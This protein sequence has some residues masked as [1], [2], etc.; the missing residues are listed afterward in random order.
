M[1]GRR[2]QMDNGRLATAYDQKSVAIVSHRQVIHDREWCQNG[3]RRVKDILDATGQVLVQQL[4]EKVPQ[5]ADFYLKVNKVVNAIPNEWRRLIRRNNAQETEN[6]DYSELTVVVI[7]AIKVDLTVS[8]RKDLYAILIPK[9]ES[10]RVERYWCEKFNLDMSECVSFYTSQTNQML[11]RK[12]RDFKWKLIN[13]CL[14]TEAKLKHIANSDGMCKLCEVEQ[15]DEDHLMHCETQGEYWNVVH[16][17][18]PRSEDIALNEEILVIGYLEQ[19]LDA[20]VINCVIEESKWV[21]WKRRC[22]IKYE[23]KWI[24]DDQMINMLKS[25]LNN[26]IEIL[27]KSVKWRRKFE[28]ELVYLRQSVDKL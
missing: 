20:G 26:R 1:D 13:R 25:R 2:R 19:R 18:L 15:E 17:C 12:V 9:Q 8:K 4:L 23:N 16:K 7:G 6:E 27:A 3:V 14:T 11:D 22:I 24:R 28:K 21:A 10:S 5:R